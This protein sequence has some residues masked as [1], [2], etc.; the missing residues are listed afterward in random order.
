VAEALY[1]G[2]LGKTAYAE[3]SLR[4]AEILGLA[5]KVHYYADGAYPGPGRFKG[6]VRVTLADGRVMEEREE[7]NRGSA[8]NPMPAAELHAKFEENAGG[9]LGADARRRLME[10]V[11]GL[12]GLGDASELVTLAVK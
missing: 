5:R 8:E 3:E 1:F 11:N 10:Q 2:K 6:E 12:D 7:Y 9:W 4:N